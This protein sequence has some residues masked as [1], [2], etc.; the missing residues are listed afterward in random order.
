M[1][2]E[3]VAEASKVIPEPHVLINVVSRRVRQLN[4]GHRPMVDAGLRAGLADIALKEIIEG[5]LQAKLP[6]KRAAA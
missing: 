6:E 5:K 2:P 4:A 3:L 1:K